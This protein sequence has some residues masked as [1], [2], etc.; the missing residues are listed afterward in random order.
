MKGMKNGEF[1]K[2]QKW[3]RQGKQGGREKVTYGVVGFK[4]IKTKERN[5][6]MFLKSFTL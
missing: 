4:N 1:M 2:D 3:Q 6:L 5:S